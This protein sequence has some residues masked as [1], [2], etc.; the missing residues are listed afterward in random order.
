M[1]KMIWIWL[2]IFV[3]AAIAF[4]ADEPEAIKQVKHRLEVE[5]FLEYLTPKALNPTPWKSLYLKYYG[6]PSSTFNYFVHLGSIYRESKTD[7]IVLAGTAH[8]WTDWFYTYS[9]V[10]AGSNVEYLPK[11]RFDQD[12]NFKFGKKRSVVWTVG[13]TYIK[14]HIPANDFILSTG[15]TFYFKKLVPEYRLFRNRSNPGNVVSYTHLASVGYG[16]EKKNWTYFT[17]ST[18]SQAYL[19]MFIS[20]PEEVRQN[21]TNISLIHRRWITNNFGF[22]IEL[23]YVELK[24]GYKKYGVYTGLFLEL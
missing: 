17:I 14:Y 2:V 1:K 16:E 22:S 18:G 20:E 12:L 9:A 7:Y 21:A 23:N 24:E 6:F 10:A 8:D 15:L 4:P 3:F 19:A 5:F 11:I 13:A